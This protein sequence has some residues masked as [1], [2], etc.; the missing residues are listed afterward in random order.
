MKKETSNKPFKQACIFWSRDGVS[1]EE[2]K[3]YPVRVLVGADSGYVGELF[4]FKNRDLAESFCYGLRVKRGCDELNY[5]IIDFTEDKNSK[6]QIKLPPHAV[7]KD[8]EVSL[9]G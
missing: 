3:K 6:S 9:Q 8:G 5:K 4:L 1:I 2:E 7:I